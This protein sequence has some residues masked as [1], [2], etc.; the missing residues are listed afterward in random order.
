MIV[1]DEA[2][3]LQRCLRSIAGAYDE[4]CIVDTGSV[5][6]TLAIAA[7]AGART[8]VFTA[9]NGPDGQIEDF[10]AART[11]ALT[12]A[13]GDWIL[14]IDADEVLGRGGAARIRRDARRDVDAVMVT[15]Q[16]GQ[17]RWLSSRLYRR[18]DSLRYVSRVHEYPE[19]DGATVTFVDRAITIT[20]RPDK[21]GKESAHER[22]VRLL[23]R[24]LDDQPDNAR[25]LFQ[26][27]NELRAGGELDAAIA[28]YRASI[29]LATYRQGAFVARYY[30]AICHLLQHDWDAAI[31]AALDGLRV[32]PRYAEAHCLLGDVYFARGELDFAR[33]WYRSALTCGTPPETPMVVQTWAYGA[34]PAQRLKR[35]ARAM[36]LPAD[37]A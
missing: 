26:L 18:S 30:L 6:A 14:Q 17:A 13:T 2:A 7:K 35:V 19:R 5:D 12:L 21:R 8:Q 20:N 1:R 37:P 32:D 4:L 31:A 16:S 9:C 22:N 33:Q 3:V 36:R 25:A 28:S 29:A 11:A 34:Y 27:G 23:R 15:M 10:A 24:E